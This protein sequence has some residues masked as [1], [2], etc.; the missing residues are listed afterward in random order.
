MHVQILQS[1]WW[2]EARDI[3]CVYRNSVADETCLFN[4]SPDLSAFHI[5]HSKC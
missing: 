2:K 4:G 3:R 1:C 5:T